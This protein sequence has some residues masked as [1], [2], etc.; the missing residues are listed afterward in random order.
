MVE[1]NC[2]S[3]NKAK[4]QLLHFG[5]NFMPL[6]AAGLEQSGWKTVAKEK[7][8]VV[9]VDSQMNVSQQCAWVA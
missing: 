5:H 6:H 4:C 7:V 1:A 9:L 3:F 8:L 2:V